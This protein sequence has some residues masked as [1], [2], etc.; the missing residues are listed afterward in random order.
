M[1]SLYLLGNSSL[2]WTKHRNLAIYDVIECNGK[3][4]EPDFWKIHVFVIEFWRVEKFE[5][6]VSYLLQ[7]V[8]K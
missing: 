2:H 5:K 1:D 7:K 8:W 3:Y 6:F 4:Y